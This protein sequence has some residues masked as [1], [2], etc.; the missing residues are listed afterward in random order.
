MEENVLPWK[1]DSDIS[2]FDVLE[3]WHINGTRYPILKDIARDILAVPV[4]T[5]TSESAFKT[6]RVLSLHC[7]KLNPQT[8]EAL[9][10]SRDWLL[11]EMQDSYP[12]K[13]PEFHRIDQAESDADT[14]T[15]EGSCNS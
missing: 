1:P 3:W 7:D 9:I 8:L 15:D 13:L 2:N 6:G 14:D 4:S 10:C 12:T 11:A 5:V